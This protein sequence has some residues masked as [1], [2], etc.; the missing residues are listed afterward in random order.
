VVT[1]SATFDFWP[2]TRHA[3]RATPHGEKPLSVIEYEKQTGKVAKD[4]QLEIWKQQGVVI[5][6]SSSASNGAFKKLG[7]HD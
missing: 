5:E 4:R 1:H 3:L 2:A 6:N 7:Y